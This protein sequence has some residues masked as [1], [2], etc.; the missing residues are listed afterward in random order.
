MSILHLFSVRPGRRL[1]ERWCRILK[2]HSSKKRVAA[3]KQKTVSDDDILKNFV[4]APGSRA[5]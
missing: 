5:A 4:A 3:K 1:P 2:N